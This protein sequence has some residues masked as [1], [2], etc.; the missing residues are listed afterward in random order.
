MFA[1]DK[2]LHKIFGHRSD[3]INLFSTDDFTPAP[4]RQGAK[5]SVEGSKQDK[6]G[7]YS[8]KQ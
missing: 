5:I 4:G 3:K 7:E 1:P 2:S 6:K 8:F